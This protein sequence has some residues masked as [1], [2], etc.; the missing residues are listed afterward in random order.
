MPKTEL[1]RAISAREHTQRWYGSHYAKLEDWARNR[2]PEPWRN[3]FFS[4]IANGTWGHDDRGTPY[5]CNAGFTVTP[6]GYISLDDAKGQ[7]ILDQIRRAEDAEM[8]RD[9]LRADLFEV[10]NVVT[11]QNFAEMQQR[12]EQAEMDMETMRCRLTAALS[13]I[14]LMKGAA[15]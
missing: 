6:S 11:A 13:E 15:R 7:L 14:A 12:A 10:R 8:E 3:E 9:E 5:K 2:L 1:E 4:C